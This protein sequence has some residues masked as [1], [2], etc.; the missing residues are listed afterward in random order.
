MNSTISLSSPSA[1]RNTGFSSWLRLTLLIFAALGLS[2]PAAA[3]TLTSTFPTSVIQGTSG[4]I[5]INGSNLRLPF[6]TTL[7]GVNPAVRVRLEYLNSQGLPIQNLIV[8]GSQVFAVFILGA[9][10]DQ[11]VTSQI[12][13][14]NVRA[15]YETNPSPG[16]FEPCLTTNSIGLEVRFGIVPTNLPRAFTGET[17]GPISLTANGAA[18]RRLVDRDRY[19]PP[20]ILLSSGRSSEPHVARR[21][22]LRSPQPT[23][24]TPTSLTARAFHQ[25]R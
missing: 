12:D 15:I 25:R 7:C 21:L 17:Y 5:S 11:T 4:T 10:Y 18:V 6:D 9:P 3:Q 22:L 1:R 19:P 14:L 20:G 13:F 23:A 2:L 8:P 16:V 24:R